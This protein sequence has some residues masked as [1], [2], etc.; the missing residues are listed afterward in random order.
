M[1]FQPRTQTGTYKAK[2][3]DGKEG[4]IPYNYVQEKTTVDTSLATPSSAAH[5]S[6]ETSE[7]DNKTD[8]VQ[9]KRRQLSQ[10]TLAQVVIVARKL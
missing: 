1:V 2:R 7:E 9:K 8:K 6:K 3:C 10:R 5:T 4:M